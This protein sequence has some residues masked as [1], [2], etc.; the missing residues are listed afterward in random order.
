MPDDK[1]VIDPAL[2]QLAREHPREVFIQKGSPGYGIQYTST[3]E[4]TP[5]VWPI[6]TQRQWTPMLYASMAA[7]YA[8]LKASTVPYRPK[9]IIGIIGD[10]YDRGRTQILEALSSIKRS[11]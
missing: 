2:V 10:L 1:P 4:D 8:T 9:Q 6:H 11:D 3:C 7:R 5:A